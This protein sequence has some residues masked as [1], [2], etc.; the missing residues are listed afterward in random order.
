MGHTDPTL[1]LAVYQQVL[2][3]G[4]GSVELLEQTLGC[5]LAQAR[6]VYNG[7]ASASEILRAELGT[8]PGSASRR[9]SKGRAPQKGRTERRDSGTNPEPGDENASSGRSEPVIMHEKNPA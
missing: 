5:T 2:D 8:V 3:M 1:T 7:E 6:A 4:K 9:R